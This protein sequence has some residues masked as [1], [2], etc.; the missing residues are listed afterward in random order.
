MRAARIA[1]GF[2]RNHVQQP[3]K[4]WCGLLRPA[5]RVL[6]RSMTN[7]PIC[8]RPDGSLIRVIESVFEQAGFD[9]AGVVESVG[10]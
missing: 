3:R 2:L 4:C 6:G 9:V 7:S 5:L 10:A 8:L 1:D